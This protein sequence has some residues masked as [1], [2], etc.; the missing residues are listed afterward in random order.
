MYMVIFASPTIAI[1]EPFAEIK[2]L[3]AF[4]SNGSIIIFSLCAKRSLRTD[5]LAPVSRSVC[6]FL[7]LILTEI[8]RSST[9][10]SPTEFWENFW[11]R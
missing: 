3:F 1:V 8:K 5:T 6:M 7:L 9:N 2:K 10:L 4:R 11:I